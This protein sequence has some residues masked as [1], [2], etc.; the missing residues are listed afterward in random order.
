MVNANAP[1][2]WPIKIMDETRPLLE[3]K[4]FHPQTNQYENTFTYW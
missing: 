2:P 3:G 4:Y 1:N